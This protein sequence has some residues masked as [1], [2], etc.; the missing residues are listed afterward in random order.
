MRL[1]RQYIRRLI[2][3]TSKEEDDKKKQ[4]SDDLLVEP[5]VR[6]VETEQEEA[7]G[8]GAVAGYTLPLGASNSTSTLRQRGVRAGQGFGGATPMKKKSR[9]RG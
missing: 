6:D 1:L 7:S 5:D 2:I 8:A 4:I 3:E 9:S